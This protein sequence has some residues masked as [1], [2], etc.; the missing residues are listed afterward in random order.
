MIGCFLGEKLP[1]ATPSIPCELYIDP[2]STS[3]RGG[4]DIMQCHVW[5]G[6]DDLYNLISGGSSP[7]P[8]PP[9]LSH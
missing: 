8:T 3:I 9:V 5:Q 1:P 4:V 6:T 2:L 7:T